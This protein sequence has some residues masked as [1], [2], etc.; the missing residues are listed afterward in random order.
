MAKN[1]S[2][3][4]RRESQL[5]RERLARDFEFMFGTIPK[6]H[7][8]KNTKTLEFRKINIFLDEAKDN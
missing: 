5:L 8:I 6:N 3:G 4:F 7:Y 1:L 2:L